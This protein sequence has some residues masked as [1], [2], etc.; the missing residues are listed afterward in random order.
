[1]R[2]DLRT[3]LRNMSPEAVASVV[4]L[5]VVFGVF[6]APLCPTLFCALAALVLRLNPAA[7]QLVN[8]LVYPL[9]IALAA[10]L[11]GLGSWLFRTPS[12]ASPLGGPRPRLGPPE[13][14]PPPAGFAS[15]L[16]LALASTSGCSGLSDAAP[17]WPPLARL[18]R[19][20]Q[21]PRL[22][23]APVR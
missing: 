1:M 16:P 8:Y 3:A 11:V 20:F 5:G 7:I 23:E 15:A 12:R 19:R 17:V 6:P 2:A 13:P 4:V 9:Q 10:P 14:T 18:F 22:H 21:R